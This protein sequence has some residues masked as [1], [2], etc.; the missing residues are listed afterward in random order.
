MK[1]FTYVQEV[2]VTKEKLHIKCFVLLYHFA[3]KNC[4]PRFSILDHAEDQRSSFESRLSTY[5]WAVLY[6]THSSFNYLCSILDSYFMTNSFQCF[7]NFTSLNKEGWRLSL[8]GMELKKQCFSVSY[9]KQSQLLAVLTSRWEKMQSEYSCLCSFKITARGKYY[10]SPAIFCLKH[11]THSPAC[12]F[13]KV[14]LFQ[15]HFA[16]PSVLPY[17]KHDR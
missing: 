4:N 6:I 2:S 7:R 10:Y 13:W 15:K 3:C 16:L 5:S 8:E 1:I 17:F 9:W 14:Y 11:P 12:I